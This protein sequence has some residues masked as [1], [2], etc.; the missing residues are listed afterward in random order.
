MF[1]TSNEL[2]NQILSLPESPGVYQYFNIKDEIIYIG[3]AKNLKKR[4][5]SYFGKKHEYEKVKIQDI[6]LTLPVAKTVEVVREKGQ[7]AT[8]YRY[9]YSDHR[10]FTVGTIISFDK[11]ER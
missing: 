8:S 7:P 5:S 1:A 3:K 2:Q 9:R 6:F 10:A 4:V 11:E